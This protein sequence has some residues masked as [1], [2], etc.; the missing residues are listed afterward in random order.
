VASQPDPILGSPGSAMASKIE[1]RRPTPSL[2]AALTFSKV[3][4]Q[5]K[6]G[7]STAARIACRHAFVWIT[8]HFLFRLFVYV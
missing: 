8:A 3:S 7:F 4:S 1:L 6:S 2:A 5:S